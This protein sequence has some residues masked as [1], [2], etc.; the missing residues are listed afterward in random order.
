MLVQV[1]ERLRKGLRAGDSIARFGGDEFVVLCEDVIDEAEAIRLSQRS[2]DFTE[3]PIAINGVE[4]L[5]TLS[6]GIALSGS[7]KTPVEELLRDADAAVPP[8]EDGRARVS[9]FAQRSR[10]WESLSPSMTSAPDTARW[11]TSSG[12]PLNC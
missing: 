10:T 1:A 6:V 12:S 3:G 8:K 7:H 4:H 2:T 11:R 9:L 5:V